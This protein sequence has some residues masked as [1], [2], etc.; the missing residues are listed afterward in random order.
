MA[1][2]TAM[3]MVASAIRTIRAASTISN[4]LRGRVD[5]IDCVCLDGWTCDFLAARREGFEGGF[6]SRMGV[7]PIETVGNLG[8]TSAARR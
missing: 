3:A 4:P 8:T 1:S 2:I 7:G 5:F 6:N